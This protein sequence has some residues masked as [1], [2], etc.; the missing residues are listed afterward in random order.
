MHTEFL[1]TLACSNPNPLQY[2]AIVCLVAV[3]GVFVVSSGISIAGITTI[4]ISLITAGASL[5]TISAALGSHVAILSGSLEALFQLVT[6]ISA[7][8]GC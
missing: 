2:V 8:L 4:L 6:T 5:E 1:L 7:I 3:S